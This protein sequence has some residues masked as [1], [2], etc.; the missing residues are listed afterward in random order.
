MA[1]GRKK[2]IIAYTRGY[3][4]RA[5]PRAVFFRPFRAILQHLS[6]VF[7]FVYP[8]SLNIALFFN[9]SVIAAFV[10]VVHFSR[11]DVAIVAVLGCAVV[12]FRDGEIA[13]FA[14]VDIG[15]A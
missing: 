1:R 6:K 10:A 2:G 14:N 5:T 13:H 9:L 4:L 12:F 15:I 7:D 8:R 11:W 3:A